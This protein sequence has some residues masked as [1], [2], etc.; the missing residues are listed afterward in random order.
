VPRNSALLG[1]YDKTDQLLYV[2]K[3]AF[4]DYCIKK[5]ANSLTKVLNDLFEPRGGAHRLP[6]AH[7]PHARRRDRVRQGPVMV[8]RDQH[9][10]P[11][12]IGC[13]QS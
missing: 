5:G 13:D 4:K 1:H 3:T 12:R 7:S 10:A 8:L 9:G 11:G 2:L 6:E